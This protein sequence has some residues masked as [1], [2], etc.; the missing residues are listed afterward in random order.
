MPKIFKI[1]ITLIC[2]FS[3]SILSNINALETWKDTYI[4]TTE[5]IPGLECICIAIEKWWS[6]DCQKPETRL[7]KCTIKWW[8][9]WVYDMLKWF[10]K[11]AL[12]I[13]SLLAIFMFV[14]AWIR[15]SIS[16]IDS[17]QR[18]PAKKQISRIIYWL[19]VLLMSWWLLSTLF[20]FIF[21]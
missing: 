19:I 1:F 21:K 18:E 14:V 3:L 8:F 20:P 9:S 2:F 17:S 7:Y 10:I 12:L 15:L 6:P 16:W 4:K 13:V 11:Y 5:D